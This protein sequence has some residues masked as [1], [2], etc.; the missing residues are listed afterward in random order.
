MQ[1]LFLNQK[2][3]EREKLVEIAKIHST[4]ASNAL[5]GEEYKNC[6]L[7]ERQKILMKMMTFLRHLDI[8]YKTIFIE[9]KQ[10]S[11]S[12]A[13]T[14]KLSKQL[15]MFIKEHFELFSSYDQVKIYYD[16]GQMD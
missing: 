6:E 4:E 10:V 16:N 14:G 5:E 9:K 8:M 2:P 12:V 15:A 1:E 7:K 11:D 3:E 13:A